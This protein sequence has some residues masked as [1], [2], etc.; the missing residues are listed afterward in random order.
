MDKQTCTPS[1]N[2]HYVFCKTVSVERV[3]GQFYQLFQATTHIDN[4]HTC[5]T[6]FSNLSVFG[7]GFNLCDDS[8]ALGSIKVIVGDL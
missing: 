4:T 5:L 6:C 1:R 7:Y 2:A 8:I 3:F